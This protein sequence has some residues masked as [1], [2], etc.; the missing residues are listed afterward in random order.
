MSRFSIEF[1][2]SHS[3]EF[4]VEETFC[5]VFQKNSGGGKVYGKEG[6]R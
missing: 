3:S 2:L 1:L 5:A 4:F 6:E